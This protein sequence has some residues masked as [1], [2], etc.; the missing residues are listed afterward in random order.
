[1]LAGDSTGENI[2]KLI[3]DALNWEKIPL[4][5]CIALSVDNANLMTGKRNG[6]FGFLKNDINHLACIGCPCHL[7]NLAAQK[8]AAC[9]PINLD[10]YLIDIY[11][12]FLRSSKKH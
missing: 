3:L 9:L 2:S 8:G 7:V 5:N 10:E 4:E 11:Y 6:V 1:M 12:Y